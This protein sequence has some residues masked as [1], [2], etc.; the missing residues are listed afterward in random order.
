MSSATRDEQRHHQHTDTADSGPLRDDAASRE[1]DYYGVLGLNDGAD[2]QE[3]KQAFRRL[4]KIWH[5]DHFA[6]ASP[7]L[8]ARA[9]RRMQALNRA[10]AVLSDPVQKVG[11]D[12][13]RRHPQR[14]ESH[15]I[16]NTAHV[17]ASY[18]FPAGRGAYQQ[19]EFGW[20]QAS[21]NPNGA[22]MFGGV[23]CLILALGTLWRISVYGLTAGLGPILAFVALLGLLVLAGFFFDKRSP[24]ARAAHNLFEHD[25][26]V[27]RGEQA[28]RH[29]QHHQHHQHRQH[30]A[31]YAGMDEEPTAFEHLVDEA[32]SDIPDEFRHY[33][34]NVVVRVKPDP[35]P[36]ELERMKV[37]P[38]SLLLGLYEGTP[39]I[40]QGA[41]GHPPEIITIFQHSIERYCHDDPER[42]R[43][44]VRATVFHELAHH[45]CMDHD[46]MP[47]WV[48]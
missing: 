35:T 39:L 32:L 4:A 44:Q 23:L 24:V 21:R 45:F 14:A 27:P 43:K 31:E 6:L 48:K 40:R 7:E 37:R 8:R 33:M 19:H 13:R 25:P 46:E 38:C 28:L 36:E 2:E 17:R 26:R 15:T 29:H 41:F 1:P 34:D 22:G 18:G 20:Q 30:Q 47:A 9:E 5:P 16:Y 42:I 3:I 11:Y 12:L 10:Y